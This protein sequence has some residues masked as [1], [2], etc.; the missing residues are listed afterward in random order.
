MVLS[1]V[2]LRQFYSLTLREQSYLPQILARHFAVPVFYLQ[3][4]TGWSR[5][6]REGHWRAVNWWA[7]PL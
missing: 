5:S 4:G 2:D 3:K 6:R 7:R 1:H